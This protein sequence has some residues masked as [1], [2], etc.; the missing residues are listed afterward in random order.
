[1]ARKVEC[2]TRCSKRS[3]G[4]N[5]DLVG[6]KVLFNELQGAWRIS[7]QWIDS[8]ACYVLQNYPTM[9]RAALSLT[10]TPTIL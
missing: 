3:H 1:M 2:G 4:A 10:P 6:S 5:E 7:P 8:A 9:V